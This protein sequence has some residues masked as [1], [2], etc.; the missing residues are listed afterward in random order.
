VLS[1]LHLETR[2]FSLR[3]LAQSFGFLVE[4]DVREALPKRINFEFAKNPR[5]KK[6]LQFQ[7]TT[8]ISISSGVRCND[9]TTETP[10]SWA[11]SISNSIAGER[12]TRRAREYRKEQLV[13][14]WFTI[15]K[16]DDEAK[17]KRKTQN[18]GIFRYLGR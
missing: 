18:S 14:D 3:Q 5:E 8:V 13:P 10:S 15:Y 7:R 2:Q 9:S 6:N 1:A 16:N 17:T 4:D 12:E 11:V